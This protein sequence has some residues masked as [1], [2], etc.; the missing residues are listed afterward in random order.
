VACAAIAISVPSLSAKLPST[1]DA[2]LAASGT[3]SALITAGGTNFV[4]NAATAIDTLADQDLST[5]DITA[6]VKAALGTISDSIATSSSG[7]AILTT[8]TAADEAIGA[9]LASDSK[10]EGLG[11]DFI[12]ALESGIVGINGV[13]GK[14]QTA[15]PDAAQAFVEGLLTSSTSGT[16]VVPGGLTVDVFASDIL[17][18]VSKNGNVDSLVAFDAAQVSGSSTTNL[19]ALATALFK[20]YPSVADKIAQ[21]VIGASV[22][23]SGT[24]SEANREAF[25]SALTTAETK[26][27]AVIAE[28][29]AF[30]DPNYA[31]QYTSSVFASLFSAGSKVA[32][33]EAG[34]IATDV[35]IALGADTDALTQVASVFSELTGSNLLPVASSATYMKDL[36]AGSLKGQKLASTTSGRTSVHRETTTSTT[37]SADEAQDFASIL[38]LFAAGI[39][40]SVGTSNPTK[41]AK[42]IGTLVKDIA[43][44]VAKDTATVIVNG[45]STTEPVAV[46]LAGTLANYIAASLGSA[47]TDV[48]AAITKGVDSVISKSIDS[49]VA[50]LFAGTPPAYTDYTKVGAITTPETTVTNL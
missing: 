31:G 35:G 34:K 27:G 21:G 29:A 33:G 49:Q 40:Q 12:K 38:D 46:Y 19:T 5:A 28:G 7:A 39:V 8:G 16:V 30:E 23:S 43:H 4:T 10:L 2:A 47:E 25:V 32:V 3:I 26:D 9:K 24:A 36:I 50:A 42:D 11:K 14:S 18:K 37:I 45:T 15:A 1:K 17:S 48:F 41:L 44:F 20:K 13:K 22:L 6:I